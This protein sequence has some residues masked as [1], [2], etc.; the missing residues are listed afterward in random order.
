MIFGRCSGEKPCATVTP[1]VRFNAPAPRPC[2]TRASSTTHTD[3]ASQPSTRPSPNSAKPTYI[4]IA[5][6]RWSAILPA[7]MVAASMPETIVVNAHG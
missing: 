2:T 7:T 4:G 5:G 6:P 3:G 1:N